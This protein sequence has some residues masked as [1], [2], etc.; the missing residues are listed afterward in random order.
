MKALFDTNILIDYLIGYNQAS[1]DTI[2][3]KYKNSDLNTLIINAAE[4]EPY[5]TADD[6]LIQDYAEEVIEGIR[7]IGKILNY[8]KIIIGIENFFLIE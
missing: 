1:G 3:L 8:P 2:K 6:R 7:I 5:V 4:C